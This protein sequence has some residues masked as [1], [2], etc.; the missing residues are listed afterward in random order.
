[1]TS[2]LPDPVVRILVC[3]N[4]DRGDD[5]AALSAIAKLLPTL[6]HELLAKVEIRRCQELHVEDL[7]DLPSGVTCLVLDA[8]A[9]VEPG[10]VVR[11]P[12]SDLLERPAFTPRSSHELPIDLVVGLAEIIREGPVAGT[13]V[14]L[15]GHGFDY[16]A[17]LSR[18]VRSAMPAYGAAI[19]AE[20]ARLT[21]VEPVLAPSAPPVDGVA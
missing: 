1:M 20:L 5:G 2:F 14:G 18:V 7:V 17:P 8:V 9:G 3:G 21:G 10:T 6:P 11:L 19:A 13:F 4:A 15:A 12:L 16:G